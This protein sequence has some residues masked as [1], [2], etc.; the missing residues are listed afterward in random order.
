MLFTWHQANADEWILI[1][2][3]QAYGDWAAGGWA[4]FKLSWS[5]YHASNNT[6][7]MWTAVF[8]NNHG[9]VFSWSKTAVTT[10]GNGSGSY[11]PYHYTPDVAFYR[12]TS[13]ANGYTTS[14]AWMR[15]L[16]IKV[17]GY[18]AVCAQRA[19]YINAYTGGWEYECF[20]MG[21]SEPAGGLTAV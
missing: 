11:G 2:T 6:L 10:V 21:N 19:L 14:D 16:Y 17:S 13:S 1:R 3:P 5:G 18:H 9:R 12:Q 15:N 4:D 8:H 7:K 20:H